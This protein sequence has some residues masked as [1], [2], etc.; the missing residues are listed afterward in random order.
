[1]YA[2]CFDSEG[3]IAVQPTGRA[4]GDQ[5]SDDEPTEPPEEAEDVLYIQVVPA[6][7]LP[8]GWSPELVKIVRERVID[9]IIRTLNG[10]DLT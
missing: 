7:P 4:G 6:H 1:M 8:P 3:T 5:F 9:Q 10:W 2:L